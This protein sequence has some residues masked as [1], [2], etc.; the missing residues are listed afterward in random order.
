[1]QEP[2]T[3][4]TEELEVRAEAAVKV[5]SQEDPGSE[6]TGLCRGPQTSEFLS[7]CGKM[8]RFGSKL[9]FY[10]LCMNGANSMSGGEAASDICHPPTMIMNTFTG[11]CFTT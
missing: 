6:Q 4:S 1:M 9:T 3:G 7:I 8:S 10:R 2:G 11:V 5:E